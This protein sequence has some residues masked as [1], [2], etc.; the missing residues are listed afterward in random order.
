MIGAG[1]VSI[2]FSLILMFIY[3]ADA[4]RAPAAEMGRESAIVTGKD[5]SPDIRA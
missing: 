5:R 3:Q 4:N 1:F 2:L